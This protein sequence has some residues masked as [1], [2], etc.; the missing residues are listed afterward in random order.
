MKPLQLDPSDSL[1]QQNAKLCKITAVL[2]RRI[3]Q[4]IAEGGPGYANYQLA[5]ALEEQVRART[6]DLD[7]ALKMLSISNARLTVARQEAEQARNDLYDALEAVQ[8]GFALFDPNDVLILSNSRFAAQ[9]PD[10][11]TKL[12]PGLGFVDYVRLVSTQPPPRAARRPHRARNG[13]GSA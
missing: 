4:E 6:K 13:R 8:E 9:L 5:A 10:V 12:G 7:D 11:A 3:E 1:E 2:M